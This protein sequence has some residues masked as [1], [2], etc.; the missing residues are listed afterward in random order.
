[1]NFNGKEFENFRNDVSKA[2][3]E[4]A[5]KYQVEIST[6]K[7]KYSDFDFSMELK[8]VKQE[9]GLDGKQK[10][11]EQH[12]FIFGFKPEHY[13]AEFTLQGDKFQ[14]IGFN[15]RSPKNSCSIQSVTSGKQYKCSDETVKRAL[16]IAK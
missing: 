12:C 10:E 9:D 7:I 16:G 3:E 1:M 5:K 13:K 4:V 14:L 11:F 15:P 2:L 8:A 6:G